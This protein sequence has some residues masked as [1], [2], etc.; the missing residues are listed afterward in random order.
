M[1]KHQKLMPL[2]KTAK[3]VFALGLALD[4]HGIPNAQSRTHFSPTAQKLA[5]NCTA[6][7]A[8]CNRITPNG[9]LWAARF[10]FSLF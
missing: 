2:E 4:Y 1:N 9:G 7:F 5:C 8:D 3:F 6:F 10:S